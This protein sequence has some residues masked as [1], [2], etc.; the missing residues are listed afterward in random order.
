MV[1]SG[2][3]IF[4]CLRIVTVFTAVAR[5]WSVS[6]LHTRMS[7][8]FVMSYCL[9]KMILFLILYILTP[10]SSLICVPLLSYHSSMG[11]V[12]SR[13]GRQQRDAFT[14]DLRESVVKVRLNDD[15]DD[16]DDDDCDETR[17]KA[18]FGF[19]PIPSSSSGSTASTLVRKFSS[20]ASLL[21]LLAPPPPPP[22]DD[23][24]SCGFG[25]PIPDSIEQI[26]KSRDAAL[27]YADNGVKGTL[28]QFMSS[29]YGGL[30]NEVSGVYSS[31]TTTPSTTPPSI[32]V[33]VR[34]PRNGSNPQSGAAN[35]V[36]GPV[37]VCAVCF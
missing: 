37:S 13:G 21:S 32:P 14:N 36:D 8:G 4:H 10:L 15:Y 7:T 9:R 19:C 20:A 23:D 11:G 26:R 16:D 18:C 12:Q 29:Q 33:G 35:I 34:A 22:T 24:N 1:I 31:R 17:T 6:S 25:T 27:A 30:E 5:R 2:D 3:S 28:G